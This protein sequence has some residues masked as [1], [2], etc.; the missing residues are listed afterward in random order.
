MHEDFLTLLGPWVLQCQCQWVIYANAPLLLARGERGKQV[1][2]RV[3]TQ[4]CGWGTTT[5]DKCVHS[6]LMWRAYAPTPNKKATPH[7]DVLRNLQNY[8]QLVTNLQHYIPLY[9]FVFRNLVPTAAMV[10]PL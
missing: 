9:Q 6:R 8:S 4:A 5:Y 3:S 10:I 1:A 7:I 2:Q